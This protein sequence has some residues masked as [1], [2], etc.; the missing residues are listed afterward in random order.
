[1]KKKLREKKE[2]KEYRITLN[3]RG[4]AVI[5]IYYDDS[6]VAYFRN[7]FINKRM[8]E[9]VKIMTGIKE[10]VTLIIHQMKM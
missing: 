1:M 4:S 9:K 10:M 3:H 8:R 7:V 2:Y 5:Y 6:H